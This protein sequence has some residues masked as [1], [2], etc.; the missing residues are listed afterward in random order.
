M[1]KLREKLEA[2]AAL[3]ALA[4]LGLLV[5]EI[6]Q[7]NELLRAQARAERA[8]IRL[9]AYDVL[10]NN[11]YLAEAARKSRTG[12]E[13]S[14]LDQSLLRTHAFQ[15]LTRW[16]F[17]FTEYRAGLLDRES[18]PIESWRAIMAGTS[19]VRKVWDDSSEDNF[20]SDFVEFMN[21]EVIR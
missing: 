11:P 1:S 5:L 19:H 2:L 6:Q 21:S 8:Q 9:D 4:G 14:E 15:L 16:Q 18:L 17:V 10:L 3:A 12:G 20:R 7:N 13:L